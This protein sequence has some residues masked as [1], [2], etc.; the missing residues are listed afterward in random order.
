MGYIKSFLYEFKNI[1]TVDDRLITIMFASIFLPWF[2][3]AI[4]VIGGAIYV[5]TCSNFIETVKRIKA[6]KILLAFVVYLFIVSLWYRNWIGLGI[7]VGM[8]CMFVLVLHYRRY[9]HKEIFEQVVD[10][11]IILS[12]VSVVYSVGEQFYYM[13]QVE[14]MSFFDIQNKPKWR[15]H[16]FFFNANYYAMMILYIEV[17]CIYKFFKIKYIQWKAYYIVMGVLNLFALYL[18]GGRIAWLCLALAVLSMVLFNKWF[19]TFITMIVGCGGVVGLLAMKPDLLP[20]LASQGLA[21]GRRTKI[22]ETARLILQDSW[23]F[24]RG[25]LTYYHS[26]E[27]YTQEYINIYGMASLKQYKLGIASQH[28]HSMF[29]EPIVSFGVVGTILISWYLLSQCKRMVMLFVRKVDYTLGSLLVGVLVCTISFCVIDFPI[30]WLQTGFLF[31]LLMGTSDMYA[32]E[33]K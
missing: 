3:S 18:T 15:V 31:L 5:L 6:S 14:G 9:V 10:I 17:M 27:S 22:W 30:F 11:M 19:K 13:S 20:R 29:I 8:F 33:I 1:Y 16:A 21:I 24:G 12:I 4:A 28:A 25:P 2:V 32:R 7:T 26:Y 23:M